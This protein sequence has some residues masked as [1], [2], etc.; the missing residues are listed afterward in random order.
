M[1]EMGTYLVPTFLVTRVNCRR[2]QRDELPEYSR[3]DAIEVARVHRENME[4]AHAEG[5]KMVMGTDSG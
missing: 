1:A 5:V 4:T 2:A 3:R